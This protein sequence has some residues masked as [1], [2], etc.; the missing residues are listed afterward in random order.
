MAARMLEGHVPFGCTAIDIGCG[1]GEL[2]GVLAKLGAARLVGSDLSSEMLGH[3]QRRLHQGSL[4]ASNAEALPFDSACADVLTSMDVIEHVP[5]DGAAV[6]EYRRVLRPGGTLYITVPA[7]QS[8][9]CHLDDEAGHFRR[10]RRFEFLDLIKHAGFLVDR[11]SYY[12]AFLAPPA[13][14]LRRTPLR[15]LVKDDEEQISSS[16]APVTAI[17]NWL[18]AAER[19]AIAQGADLPGG[20]SI[21][22]RAHA[23]Q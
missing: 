3:A 14:V 1:T 8:L 9:W 11:C 21:L 20:L 2:I 18:S 23:P 4:L 7:Y 6:A 15:R 16:S 17:L 12:F 5:N 19:V 10:Y 22:L 13:F